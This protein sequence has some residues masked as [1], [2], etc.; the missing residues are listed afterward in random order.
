[1]TIHLG[2]LPEGLMHTPPRYPWG[3][4]FGGGF[5]STAVILEC[6]RR[7]F[8]P[9][10][11]LF[12]DTG[13]ERPETIQHVHKMQQWLRDTAPSNWP[14]IT[15]VRWIRREGNFEPLHEYNLRTRYLPS[16]AY[17]Y[18]G[19]T[20]KYKIGPMDKWRKANGFQRGA[21]AVGYNASEA[22][23]IQTACRRGDDPKFTAWYPLVA[24]E[25]S[26]DRVIQI[27]KDAGFDIVKS[28]CFMCP[29][30]KKDEWLQLK[31]D[32][33]EL[34]EK[35][36]LIEETAIKNGNP[37]RGG[38]GLYKGGLSRLRDTVSDDKTDTVLEDRCHHGGCFT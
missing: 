21:F 34:F 7:K 4:N 27:V 11:I 5:D 18:A 17:G 29:N 22:R 38:M 16:K 35:A 33:P 36:V 28:S 20:D 13:S 9:D 10:W 31:E 30:M 6:L 8:K 25:L 1:M 24:W 19:C 37:G 3:I 12:A 2:A 15:V 32:H 14:E 26:R 23:R